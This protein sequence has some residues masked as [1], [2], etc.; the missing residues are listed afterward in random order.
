MKEK[1]KSQYITTP[2]HTIDTASFTP[3]R[4]DTPEHLN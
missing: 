1:L 3:E 4:R 2:K